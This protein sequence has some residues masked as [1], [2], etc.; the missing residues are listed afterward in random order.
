MLHSAAVPLNLFEPDPISLRGDTW[1][2][3][4]KKVSAAIHSLE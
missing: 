1:P 2:A 4:M 3:V